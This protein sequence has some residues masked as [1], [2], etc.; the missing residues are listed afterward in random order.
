M[1]FYLAHRIVSVFENGI[2]KIA[3]VGDC[4]LRV[5]R[6]GTKLQTHIFLLFDFDFQKSPCSISSDV[7]IAYLGA[8]QMIFST[9]P[10]EHYFDC[11][12]QLSSEAVTQTYL[13]AIV[14]KVI[15]GESFYTISFE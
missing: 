14:W 5:I 6:K 13:D 15:Y 7:I 10:L 12:Y 4:G 2:L 8:G 1:A 3:S 9:F 11:P